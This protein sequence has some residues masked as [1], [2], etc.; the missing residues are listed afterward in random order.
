MA[1][2]IESASDGQLDRLDRAILRKLRQNARVPTSQLASDLRIANATC[3][4]RIRKLEENE[5]IAKYTI[6]LNR[7]RAAITNF[8]YV[9]IALRENS[10]DQRNEFVQYLLDCPSLIMCDW[11]EGEYDFVAK[12]GTRSH[13]EWLERHRQLNAH[14][15]CR[16]TKTIGCLS[17]VRD[18]EIGVNH[19]FQVPAR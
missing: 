17:S 3:R 11:V 10:D 19:L 16:S 6:L 5:Y 15:L 18:Y 7:K 9:L 4:D 13:E 14:P 12:F 1:R 2:R 8:K